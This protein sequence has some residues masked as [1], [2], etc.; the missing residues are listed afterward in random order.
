MIFGGINNYNPEMHSQL[1]ATGVVEDIDIYSNVALIERVQPEVETIYILSDH[2]VTGEAVRLQ[3]EQFL[4]LNTEYQTM[5]EQLVPENYQQL[6]EFTSLLDKSSAVLFWVYYRDKN[7]RVAKKMN[8]SSSIKQSKSPI[9]MVHDLGLGS[10]SGWWINFEWQ[11]TRPASR[12]A[13]I[14]SAEF[15]LENST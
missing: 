13:I 6:I 4:T 3:V 1:R 10:W 5:V 12:P 14:E 2:S 7:G 9:Y 15:H 11:N 8:G